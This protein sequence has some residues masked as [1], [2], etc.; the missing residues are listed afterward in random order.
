MRGK[1]DVNDQQISEQ[2]KQIRGNCE[3]IPIEYVTETYTSQ[4]MS[5]SD[6]ITYIECL[7]TQDQLCEK[8]KFNQKQ[9]NDGAHQ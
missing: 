8:W 6:A 1:K 3:T 5:K 2:L 7:K 4:G 9:T